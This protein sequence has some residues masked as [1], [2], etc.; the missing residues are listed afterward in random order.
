MA[1]AAVIRLITFPEVRSES[2]VET[3]GCY[4]GGRGRIIPT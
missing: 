2:V 3:V 4:R 1:T